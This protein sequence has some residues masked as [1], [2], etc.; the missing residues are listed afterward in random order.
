MST[1][2]H[3]GASPKAKLSQK[4]A[5]NST[6]STGL[7]TR[8]ET[9][10]NIEDK[11]VIFEREKGPKQQPLPPQQYHSRWMKRQ[12]TTTMGTQT[13]TANPANL[14]IKMEGLNL[15]QQRETELQQEILHGSLRQERLKKQLEECFWKRRQELATATN[16][17][18][19]WRTQGIDMIFLGVARQDRQRTAGTRYGSWS[20]HLS[21]SGTQRWSTG[22]TW[23]SL[24]WWTCQG[25]G[26]SYRTS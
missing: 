2:G 16:V 26:T 15:A 13:M 20:R 18:G 19:G 3:Q 25:S 12:Q 9:V 7:R 6:S 1:F 4:T 8:T 24:T 23:Q 22:W 5:G 11:E 10:D 14:I 17:A 21:R